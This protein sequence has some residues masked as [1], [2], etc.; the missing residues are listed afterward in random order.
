MVKK[1]LKI[2]VKDLNFTLMT[3]STLLAVKCLLEKNPERKS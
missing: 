2:G 1:E 3:F